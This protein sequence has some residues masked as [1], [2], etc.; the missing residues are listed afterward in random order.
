MDAY[1]KNEVVVPANRRSQF[2]CVVWEGT[3]VERDRSLTGK[4]SERNLS[5]IEEKGGTFQQGAVSHAGDR[6]RP[7]TSMRNGALKKRV[8]LSS[9]APFRMLVTGRVLSLCNPKSV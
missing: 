7:V 3:C 8:E 4:R 5:I 2:L 1:C 9:R 6:T